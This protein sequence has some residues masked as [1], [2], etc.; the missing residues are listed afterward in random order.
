MTLC[1]ARIF[2]TDVAPTRCWRVIWWAVYCD[3]TQGIPPGRRYHSVY[4][5]RN[6][7]I[8]FSKHFTALK[9]FPCCA[10]ASPKLACCNFLVIKRP[11]VL[12]RT[13]LYAP[14]RGRTL[15]VPINCCY[16]DVIIFTHRTE[17]LKSAYCVHVLNWWPPKRKHRSIL[18][19]KCILYFSKSDMKKC[20]WSQLAGVNI[21][22]ASVSAK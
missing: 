7:K 10:P 8:S 2:S 1:A 18:Q 20:D 6:R 22:V 17:G 14:Q 16:S 11:S 9:T 21:S 13:Y 4:G 3:A 12:F 5:C 19:P 15:C